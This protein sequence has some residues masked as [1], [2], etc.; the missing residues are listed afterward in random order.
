MKYETIDVKKMNPFVGAE[1]SGIDLRKPLDRQQIRDVYQAFLDHGVIF[2]HGQELDFEQHMTFAKYFGPVHIHVGGEGTASRQIEGYPAIR[3]QHFDKDSARVSGE[4]WHSDQT[5]AEIP[6]MGSI[7]RQVIV[8][9]NGG[10]DTLFASMYA[11]Y[12]ALSPTMQAFLENLE[13]EHD[14]AKLFNKGTKTV[15][16]KAVH[17]IAP[18][19][20]ETGRK[21]LF[22]NPG[23]TTRILGL[24]P[25]ESDAILGFLYA[26]CAK[27][28]WQ[29]RFHWGQHSIAFWDNRCTQHCAIWDYWPETRSGYRIQVEGVGRPMRQRVA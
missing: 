20:P 12:E 17:P 18:V 2:F 22:V 27:P 5:C 15:Y 10:G 9:E 29:I 8:P 6:P 25:E 3:W 13:A 11:A 28:D 21:L 1:V 16:P 14:G 23:F 4:V 24:E 19:H 7:L 26:H